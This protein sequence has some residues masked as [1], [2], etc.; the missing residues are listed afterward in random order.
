MRIFKKKTIY[1]IKHFNETK[2]IKTI[3]KN[4]DKIIG[5]LCPFFGK[6]KKDLIR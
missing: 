6:K 1:I 3:H 5:Q 2:I 4:L